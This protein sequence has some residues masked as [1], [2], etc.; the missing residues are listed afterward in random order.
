MENA[1]GVTKNRKK[2]R[3]G[4][5]RKQKNGIENIKGILSGT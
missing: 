4:K 1:N 3:K 5:G 2:N